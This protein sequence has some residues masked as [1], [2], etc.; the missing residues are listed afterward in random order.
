MTVC[1][2]IL[3]R[4]VLFEKHNIST[5]TILIATVT[6]KGHSALAKTK[7][8]KNVF[9]QILNFIMGNIRKF[10]SWQLTWLTIRNSFYS[11]STQRSSDE[12]ITLLTDTVEVLQRFSKVG[13][14]CGQLARLGFN[15][16]DTFYLDYDGLGL[17][18]DLL[19]YG[20]NTLNLI[21]WGIYW[22]V[23]FFWVY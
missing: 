4:H 19:I 11:I 1:T 12:K 6:L 23:K 15:V 14:S 16:S 20:Q 10:I 9:S 5:Y 13:T 3:Y 21:F 7:R 17:G 2:K 18:K 22:G 8:Y